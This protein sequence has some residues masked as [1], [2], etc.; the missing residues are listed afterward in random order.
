VSVALEGP[1]RSGGVVVAALVRQ[2]IVPH[3]ARP[4]LAVT[5][6]R[7]PVALLIRAEGATLAFG[8][9]G[10][11]LPPEEIEHLRPGTLAEIAA[12]T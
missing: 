5:G 12:E 11:A 2:E 10:A 3:R 1:V 7:H 4:G 9:D 8:P 6:S